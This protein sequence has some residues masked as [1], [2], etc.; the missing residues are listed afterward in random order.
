MRVVSLF[1]RATKKSFTRASICFLSAAGVV[2][3]QGGKD[4]QGEEEEDEVFH[5][6]GLG[7]EMFNK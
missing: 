3:R 4:G 5:E 6:V 2:L 7:D 1:C